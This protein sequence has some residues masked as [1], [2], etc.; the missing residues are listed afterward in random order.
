MVIASD[1]TPVQTVPS[2]ITTKFREAFEA[3]DPLTGGV[4]NEFKD[5]GD[6][7]TV[8]GNAVAASYL[9]I[10][11]SPLNAAT[12]SS[13]ETITTFSMPLELAI[14]I[15]ISQRT[16][17]QELSVEIVD[18]D[19]PLADV[20]DIEIQDV[21]Q[22]TTTLTVNTVNDH[23][24]TPGK[25]VGIRDS[26]DPRANYP[27]LVVAS[28][29]SP[30]QVTFTAGPGGTI[31]S[32]TIGTIAG[33]YIYFRERLGRANNGMSQIFENQSATN[34][35]L[36]ARSESGDASPSGTRNG[37][38]VVSVASSASVQMINSAWTY[39]FAATSEFRMRVKADRIQ[40][41][42]GPVNSTAQTS[43][44]LTLTD[45]CP[46][47]SALYK[48][49]IRATNN[50]ALTVPN[51]RIVSA[52]K[53]GTTT[54]TIETDVPHGY[55]AGSPVVVYGI[56]NQAASAFPNL[57]AATAV[58]SVIDATHYT[59]V[60]GTASTVTSYGGYCAK[61]NGGNLMSSLGGIAQVIQS[62]TL[63]TLTN[64]VRQL[65]LVGSA[66]WSGL[67][68]ADGTEVVGARNT[69]DG[70]SLGIDG[71]WKVANIATTN[72]TLEPME[73]NTP[74][75][76]FATVNCGG[77]VIKRTEYRVHFARVFDFEREVVEIMGGATGDISGAAPV[78]V[79]N[80]LAISTLPTLASVTTVA[81]VTSVGTAGT[82]P[83]PA[84]P[85]FLNSAATTNGALVITG[86]SG[87]QTVFSTN[88]GAT[89]AYVKLYNKA[90]APTV[91][92]DV[93][94]MIIAVPAAVGGVPGT[95]SPPIGYSGYRFALGLGIAITAG[96]ADN[97][98]TAVAAGQVKVK[99]SRTV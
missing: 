92:T 82:P 97:D 35:S 66:A 57:T 64:G 48:L 68:I 3:Y 16:L 14:A 13:I 2:N 53:T 62:A 72:L 80:S 15:S 46:N 63:T 50:K 58:A 51:A 25:S 23:G 96:A 49:R 89:V 47:P 6:I 27:A 24:L 45:V 9:V 99:L 70:A 41:H 26:G 39:A 84:T 59:I 98:T 74:P 10:S 76:D 67:I 77:G 43:P 60:I 34:A 86:T 5:S 31:A 87:L 91:G 85:F 38:H 37:S 73:G 78:A 75:A 71:A 1:Q 65:V 93:P 36:Y 18:T 54:A 79:Q 4:W 22:T 90:T 7:I 33:G 42:D 52:V 95:A 12:E 19:T 88:T 94:E 32:Q 30:R 8:D 40:W 21:S 81:A 83:V 55:V 69:V 56:A 44:R 28:I 61:V 11:K 29:P 17:G 20:A